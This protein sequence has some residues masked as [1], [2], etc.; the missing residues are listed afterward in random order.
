MDTLS[1]SSCVQEEQY[2]DPKHHPALLSRVAAYMAGGTLCDVT[3]TTGQGHNE[4]CSISQLTP[5][6]S[7]I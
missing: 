2:V 7:N 3:I 4:V 5:A 1:V 6:I